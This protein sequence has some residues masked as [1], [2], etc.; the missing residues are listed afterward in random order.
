M[1]HDELIPDNEK[2]EI[3]A[4]TLFGLKKTPPFKMPEAYFE[5]FSSKLLQNISALEQQKQQAKVDVDVAPDFLTR[6]LQLLL[7]PGLAAPII[8]FVA[9]LIFVASGL[10]N[11][12]ADHAMTASLNDEQLKQS[13]QSL[14]D[15]DI[16]NYMLKHIQTFDEEQL[17]PEAQE[18]VDNKNV[19]DK[20]TTNSILNEMDEGTLSDAAF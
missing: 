20:E 12:S 1:N 5:G 7:R 11:R 8:T 13:L 10:N 19:L 4:P 17:L 2:L 6:V 9:L 18:N 16:H 3:V 15:A 14:P